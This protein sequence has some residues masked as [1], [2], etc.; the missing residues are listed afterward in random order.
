[1]SPHWIARRVR[2]FQ[3]GHRMK[4][5]DFMRQETKRGI[6]RR[7]ASG[8]MDPTAHDAISNV[9]HSDSERRKKLL[10]KALRATAYALGFT[11]TNRIDL[12]DTET[13]ERFH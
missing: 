3:W 1:M 2:A 8:C 9:M 6:S 4:G 10:I 5:R 11:I 13:G 12:V 7:N